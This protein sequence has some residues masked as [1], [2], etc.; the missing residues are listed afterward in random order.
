METLVRLAEERELGLFDEADQVEE[1]ERALDVRLGAVLDVVRAV[2][3][4]CELR[5][6]PA[7]DRLV[8]VLATDIWSSSNPRCVKLL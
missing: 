3:Q 8:E 6:A 2:E 1:V 4:L 5:V 7:G